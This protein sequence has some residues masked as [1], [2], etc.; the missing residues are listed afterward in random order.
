MTLQQIYPAIIA[1]LKA[2]P[3]LQAYV[4]SSNIIEG[5]REGYPNFPVIVVEAGQN[6]VMEQKMPYEILTETVIIGGFVQ[7]YDK[8]HQLSANQALLQLENDIKA[9]L[10]QQ[11][12]QTLGLADVY[13]VVCTSSQRSNRDYPVRGFEMNVIVTYRQDRFQRN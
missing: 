7:V 4:S 5:V 13:S 8:E 10:S 6:K 3:A 1:T 9:A 2:W 11:S 12:A